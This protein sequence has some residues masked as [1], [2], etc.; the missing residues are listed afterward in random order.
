MLETL[1]FLTTKGHNFEVA[2]MEACVPISHSKLLHRKGGGT[3]QQGIMT[4]KYKKREE[5]SQKGP[6]IRFRI[7]YKLTHT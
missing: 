4:M 6:T 3:A 2:N 5:T 1:G 7:K